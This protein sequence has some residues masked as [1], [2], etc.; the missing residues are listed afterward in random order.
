MLLLIYMK[1]EYVSRLYESCSTKKDATVPFIVKEKC[2]ADHRNVDQPCTS[3]INTQNEREKTRFVQA[4]WQ[5]ANLVTYLILLDQYGGRIS[6]PEA[7]EP[8]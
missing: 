8:G 7:D 5:E 4:G 1:T 2:R 6:K 3:R